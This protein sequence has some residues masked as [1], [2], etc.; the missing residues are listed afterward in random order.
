MTI[1]RFIY[2]DAE[3]FVSERTLTRWHENSLYIQGRNEHDTLPRTFRKS[4]IQ[5]FLQGANLLQFDL[6]PPAPEPQPRAPADGRAQILFT[7]FKS[8]DRSF[9]EMRAE[10]HGFHVMKTASKALAVLCIGGNA[11]PSKVEKA[12]AAGAFIVDEKEFEHL[13][14]TGEIPC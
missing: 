12:R 8:A 1:L 10:Q 6:A 2:R 3:G 14:R 7:G 13:L 5:E 11:G 4:R 9:L